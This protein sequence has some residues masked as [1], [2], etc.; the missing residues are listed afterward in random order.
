MNYAAAKVKKDKHFCV[1]WLPDGKAFVIYDIKEFTNEVIPKFFKASKFCSF[2]RKL[3]R[4]GFR[5]LNRGIG[6]DEPIIFG[7]EFFQ[8]DNAD[9]MVNMRSITAASIRKRES[10]L[11]R[12][13]LASKK[14]ALLSW[15]GGNA[16]AAAVGSQDLKQNERNFLLGNALGQQKAAQHQNALAA[17]AA[18]TAGVPVPPA[19]TNR[20]GAGGGLSL[21]LGG[22]GAITATDL[23][24]MSNEELQQLYRTCSVSAAGGGLPSDMGIGP[25]VSDALTQ[26]GG[27]LPPQ[28]FGGVMPSC[29]SQDLSSVLPSLPGSI[30]HGS[31]NNPIN[32]SMFDI[33]NDINIS[34]NSIGNNNGLGNLNGINGNIN[35]NLSALNPSFPLNSVTPN[36][37]PSELAMFGNNSANKQGNNLSFLQH[38]INNNSISTGANDTAAAINNSISSINSFHNT[39]NNNNLLDTNGINA[40]ANH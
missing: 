17:A 36:M 28:N 29:L 23:S 13:M 34:G 3:Y 15:N 33:N 16:A 22:D 30:N 9:L 35:Q 12:H 18:V 25:V 21:G 31:F 6:P 19:S 11:L 26:V 14:R 27:N 20:F 39:M 40:N 8:Q 32:N 38:Q 1:S 37:L 24:H 7:N 2:T 10:N 4:W 5:Q